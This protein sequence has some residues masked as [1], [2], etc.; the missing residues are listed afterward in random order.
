[1]TF[2]RATEADLPQ[3]M[4]IVAAAQRYLAEQRVDQWQD[5]YPSELIMRADIETGAAYVLQGPDQAVC[6]IASIVYTGEPTYE[7]IVSGAWAAGEPYA[8][9]HRVAVHPAFRGK[10]G[11]ARLMA[12]AEASI[13]AYGGMQSIRVDTH[14]E[15]LPMRRMLEKCGFS[16]RGVIYLEDGAERIA[17]EKAL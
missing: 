15:N 11:A 5:G 7:T 13:R 4:E 10:G 17:L 3:I 14:R 6:A 9:L 16:V 12:E 2:R 1:M 8:C